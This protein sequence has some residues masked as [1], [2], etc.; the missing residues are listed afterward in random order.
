MTT[1]HEHRRRA[2]FSRVRSARLLDGPPNLTER[3]HV[4]A[5]EFLST[6]ANPG[7]LPAMLSPTARTSTARTDEMGHDPL[8]DR[9]THDQTLEA[10]RLVGV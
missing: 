10:G 6:L 5:V 7:A 2:E 3:A 1:V 4:E 8:P 9:P